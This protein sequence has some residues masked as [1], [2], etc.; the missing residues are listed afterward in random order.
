MSA[1]SSWTKLFICDGTTKFSISAVKF[2]RQFP[3][4][5]KNSTILALRN[6]IFLVEI[7]V[8]IAEKVRMVRRTLSLR[9]G[10]KTHHL[11]V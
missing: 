9:F 1:F 7:G 3:G 10:E 4:N 5:K 11:I 8:D 6:C 2:Y